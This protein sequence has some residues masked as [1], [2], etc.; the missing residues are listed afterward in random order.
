[1]SRLEIE[2]LG[3]RFEHAATPAVEGVSFAIEDGSIAAL[4]GESGAGK[5]TVLRLVAGL[6]RPD[7]GEIRLGGRL[8]SS[9]R[10]LVPPE[11]RGI[12]FVFQNHALFPHLSVADNI[13]FG[14]PRL[15]RHERETEVS[16]LLELVRLPGR[17][18]AMP[19]EL[20]GGERQRVAL[21]RT[22]APKPGLIL[23]DEPFS[24]LDVALRAE[25][26][27]EIGAIL[28]RLRLTVLIVTH[29]ADDALSLADRITVIRG[30]RI[31]QTGTPAE[32]YRLPANRYV[33]AFFGPCNFLP[34]RLFFKLPPGPWRLYRPGD[35]EVWLRPRDLDVVSS[36]EALAA[37][38]PTGA[39]VGCRFHGAHWEI[40]FRPDDPALP[41]IVSHTPHPVR[42]CGPGAA[43]LLP[44]RAPPV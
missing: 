7:A 41:E 11:R 12:G 44:R 25:M 18:A 14:L 21:A 40:R 17:A 38:G 33:A 31:Q 28:R 26:R 36:A 10:S 24:S 42:E 13:A 19:H 1:M 15:S 35:D 4:V 6:D 22:L 16:R 27:A 20:S 2:K 5:S 34:G 39:V 23:L 30:G 32:L 29:D 3:R 8:V 37:G 9:P 43:G